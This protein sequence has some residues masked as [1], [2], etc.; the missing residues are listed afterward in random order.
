MM[1]AE[2]KN[3]VS[4]IW[5]A[6]DDGQGISQRRPVTLPGLDPFVAQAWKNL[7]RDKGAGYILQ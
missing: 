2:C 4:S 5:Q 3:H 6:A 1:M 7:L